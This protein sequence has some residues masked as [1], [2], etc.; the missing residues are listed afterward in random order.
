VDQRNIAQTI[1]INVVVAMLGLVKTEVIVEITSAYKIL[2]A[3]KF[4]HDVPTVL[5]MLRVA[6]LLIIVAE[7]LVKIVSIALTIVG[8]VM[9][10]I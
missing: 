5:N 4:F 6:R 8:N 7:G 3:M 9:H 10:A 1:D 2:V